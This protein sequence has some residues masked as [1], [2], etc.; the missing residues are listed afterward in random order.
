MKIATIL[1]RLEEAAGRFPADR[2]TCDTVKYGSAEHDATK[3]AVT[4]FPTP[5]VIRAAA[6]WGSELLITHEPTAFD[7]V[8]GEKVMEHDAVS[9]AKERLILE[10]GLTVYRFHDHP[11]VHSPD[12]IDVG[13]LELLDLEMEPAGFQ[14]TSYPLSRFILAQPITPRELARRMHERMGIG[15]PRVAGVADIPCTHLTLALGQRGY[16]IQ[17]LCDPFSEIVISGE[18]SEWQQGEYARDAA[19]LGIAKALIFA[20]HSGSERPGMA[21][22][23]KKLAALVPEVEVRYFDCGDTYDL[24]A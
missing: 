22:V 20:G 10:K 23:A 21:F 17:E 2:R 18:C 8:A 13:F 24:M 19:Q 9:T 3:V 15:A 1:D 16:I 4:M 5:D 6:D 11:H 7:R 12:W 14:G